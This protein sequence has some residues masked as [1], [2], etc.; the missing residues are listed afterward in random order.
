MPARSGRIRGPEVRAIPDNLQYG[1]GVLL[2]VVLTSGAVQSAFR[3]LATRN[4]RLGADAV[5]LL[6]WCFEGK[7]K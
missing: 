6:C 3:R 2:D 4:A 7:L 5:N 1:N